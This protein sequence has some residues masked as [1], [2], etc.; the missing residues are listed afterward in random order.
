MESLYYGAGFSAQT[1]QFINLTGIGTFG[2]FDNVAG[3]TADWDLGA[4]VLPSATTTRTSS[5]PS[6]RWIT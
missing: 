6:P 3:F 2:R 1:G 4:I 5:P